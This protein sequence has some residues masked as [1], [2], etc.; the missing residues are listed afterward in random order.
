M[1]RIFEDTASAVYYSHDGRLLV[2]VAVTLGERVVSLDGVEVFRTL[3]PVKADAFIA[4]YDLARK[5]D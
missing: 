4:G 1:S 5:T 2:E 3:D